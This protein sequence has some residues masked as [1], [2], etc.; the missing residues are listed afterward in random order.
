MWA[1]FLKLIG[2]EDVTDDPRFIRGHRRMKNWEPIAD[3]IHQWTVDKTA[4]EVIELCNEAEIPCAPVNTIPE[5]VS[6]P[7][8]HEREMIVNVE[9]P[10]IGTIPVTGVAVKL[11]ETPGRIETHAPALGEH[12]EEIYCGLLGY[13]LGD[14]SKLKEERVI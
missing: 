3:M 8:I 5:A 9:Q 6:D 11:S 2:R 14:L 10:G 4:N 1:R 12:N 7:Q 13:D